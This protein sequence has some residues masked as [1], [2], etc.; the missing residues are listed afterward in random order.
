MRVEGLRAVAL[1]GGDTVRVAA[2]DGGA[3]TVVYWFQSPDRTT[4]DLAARVW[5]DVSGR[6]H[7][8]VQV[9]LVVDA[10]LD[11]TS[12]EGLALVADLRAAVARALTEESP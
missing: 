8:W 12:P 1:G 9:S 4:G 7:R 3:R 10:P 11:V 6:E 5:E 2:A